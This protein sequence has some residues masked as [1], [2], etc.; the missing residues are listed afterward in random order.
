MPQTTPLETDVIQFNSNGGNTIVV[1]SDTNGNMTFQDAI[2]SSAISLVDL[3]GLESSSSV[4]VVGKKYATIQ[5]AL[6]AIPLTS[7]AS[8][9]SVVLIPAGV[10]SES[11]SIERDGV[12]LVGLG[13]VEITGVAGTSTIS[14]VDTG[15]AIPLIS[16]FQNIVVSKSEDAER[17]ISIV[18]TDGTNLGSGGIFFEN[19]SIKATGVGTF[20]LYVSVANKVVLE[21]CDTQGS[22][23]TAKFSVAQC[24]DLVIKGSREI[25]NV[26]LSYDSTLD[27]P[28][29]LTSSYSFI[30]NDLCGDF[31]VSLLG[32]GSLSVSSCTIGDLSIDGTQSIVLV[33]CVA[34]NL[35]VSGT[36]DS[37]ITG[38]SYTSLGGDPT[39]TLSLDKVVG[40]VAFT[41]EMNKTVQLP[42]PYPNTL[43]MVL[44]E[45]YDST[46]ISPEH[47]FVLNK[48]T[49]SFEIAYTS[50]Q[51]F[52]VIYQVLKQ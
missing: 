46:A 12:H 30:Q 26:E 34:E 10:Y 28:S 41:N 48:T 50:N 45:G 23:A 25:P 13:L 42:L 21:G 9:P 51:T 24:A 5:E 20:A 36:T 38:T 52:S 4:F 35:T 17:A 39:T 33:Q 47:P 6:D 1:S 8:N 49:T 11:I 3:A 27:K 22:S 14:I 16:K 19:C 29:T 31:L 7:S 40:S 43:Y 18:G 44:L 37:T 2:V 32:V 15:G